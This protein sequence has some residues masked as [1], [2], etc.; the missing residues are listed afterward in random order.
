MFNDSR[1]ASTNTA[2]FTEVVHFKR[3]SLHAFLMFFQPVNPIEISLGMFQE[4]LSTP[5]S[6][7]LF[8][9]F[10]TPRWSLNIFCRCSF[11]KKQSARGG[12]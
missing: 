1:H 9:A 6:L 3:L 12:N 5:F 4:K 8:N 11:V 2:P 7:L 10:K